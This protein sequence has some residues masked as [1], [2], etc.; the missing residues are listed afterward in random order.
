MP[1]LENTNSLFLNPFDLNQGKIFAKMPSGKRHSVP[2]WVLDR[3]NLPKVSIGRRSRSQLKN[4]L[5]ENHIPFVNENT[6]CANITHIEEAFD[7]WFSSHCQYYKWGKIKQIEQRKFLHMIKTSLP[8]IQIN[9]FSSE[10]FEELKRKIH[11]KNNYEQAQIVTRFLKDVLVWLSRNNCSIPCDSFRLNTQCV[12]MHTYTPSFLEG[13]RERSYETYLALLLL[14][15]SGIDISYLK[16]IKL[17]HFVFSEQ[18]L[19]ADLSIYQVT[20]AFEGSLRIRDLYGDQIDTITLMGPFVRLLKSYNQHTPFLFREAVS[21][22]NARYIHLVAEQLNIE[23]PVS[24]RQ[25]KEAFK[26]RQ[27]AQTSIECFDQSTTNDTTLL[28]Q[29]LNQFLEWLEEYDSIHPPQIAP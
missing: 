28:L 1:N 18:A 12:V 27:S 19:T 7:L 13:M 29:E 23:R 14:E 16:Y 21:V 5:V 11:Q 26:V 10:Y 9:Q 25:I 15:N 2:Y 4:W 6:D 17:D 22:E 8:S 24:F 3:P 20:K